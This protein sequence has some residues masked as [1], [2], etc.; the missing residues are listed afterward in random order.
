[1]DVAKLARDQ[2]VNRVAMG[3]ALLVAPGIVGSVWAGPL[4]L[5]DDR[6]KVL[7]R[8]LGARDLT[9]GVAALVA[10]REGDRTWAKRAF[11]AHAWA[12]A[13]DFLAIAAAGDRLPRMS[14][15]GGGFMAASSAAVAAGY[16]R[17]LERGAAAT[18]PRR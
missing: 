10:L 7:A 1:M 6:A 13:V 18:P 11:A 15:L 16:A 8:A 9:L 17:R 5:D 2:A 12:D 14:L 3:A 4:A